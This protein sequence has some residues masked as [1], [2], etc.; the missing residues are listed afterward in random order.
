MPISDSYQCPKC[1]S[2]A[3][4]NLKGLKEFEESPSKEGG[5]TPHVK[6]RKCVIC[7]A[8]MVYGFLQEK[9]PLTII[10]LL[11]LSWRK[12]VAFSRGYFVDAYACPGCGKVEMWLNGSDLQENPI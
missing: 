10:S 4:L 11:A 1:H 3:T 8:D 6:T 9:T 2:N 12:S 5:K 7:G